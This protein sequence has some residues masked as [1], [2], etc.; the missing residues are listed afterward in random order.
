VAY[1]ASNQK[2]LHRYLAKFDFR[3]TRRAAT[4][5]NETNRL[6]TALRCIIGKQLIC[7][8]TGI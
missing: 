3:Y 5:F 8:N 2:N 7:E 6:R 4:G 1:A